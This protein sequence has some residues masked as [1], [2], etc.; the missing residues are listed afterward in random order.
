MEWTRL[1]RQELS[2]VTG[3]AAHDAEIIEELAEDLAQR[4]EEHRTHEATE[5]EALTYI[6]AE[7]GDPERLKARI[8][9]SRPARSRPP[10]P[11]R[12]GTGARMTSDLW[13][14]VRYAA[15]ILRRSPGFSLP[16]VLT[17]AVGIGAVTAIFS[18]IDGVLLK[19]VPY[20]EATRLIAV[21][22]T[23]RDSATE[24]EPASVPD[25]LDFGHRS[26]LVEAFGAIAAS[27]FNLTPSQGDPVRLAGLDV[28]PGLFALLGVRP[29]VGRLFSEA[30]YH[31]RASDVVL[32]SERLWDRM[33]QRDASI[34]GRTIRLDDRPRI[35]VGILPDTA[36]LGV[37]QW[38]LAADY[39]RGFA[40]R[41]ARS[42]VDAWVPL[43]LDPVALPRNTHPIL[44]VGRVA[45]GVSLDAA[46]GEMAAIMAALEREFPDDNKARGAHV[47]SLL[48]VV[49]GPVRPALGVLAAAVVL[50]LLL[51]SANVANLVLVRGTT[52][53]REVALRTAL[54]AT[55]ARLTRQFVIEN[56]LIATVAAVVGL[57]IA[58]GALR[59]L[60]ATAP[61]DVPRITTVALDANLFAAAL[62]LA[63]ILAVV[64]GA[65]PALQARRLDLSSVLISDETRTATGSRRSGA[66]RAWL[67][68]GEIALAVVLTVGA[69]LLIRSLWTLQAV[70]PGF[71]ADGVLKAEFQLPPSRYPQDFKQWP[72]FVEIHRFNTSLLR[73]VAGLPGIEAAALA[74]QHPLDAGFTN[75]F[76]VVG[77]EAEGRDW[78][79]I[80]LRRVTP[81]YFR[82][83]QVPLVEGRLFTDGDVAASKSV[84][85]I[86]EAAAAR[87]FP[88]RNPVGQQIRFW[89]TTRLVVGLVG[90]ERFHGLAEAPPPATYAPLAQAPSSAEVLLV[91]APDALAMSAV[92]RAAITREDPGLAIFGIEPL[93]ATLEESMSRRRFVMLLLAILAGMAMALAAVGIHAVLSYDV[94]RRTRE[95]GIR[96]ALG[97]RPGD[98]MR[99][100][101]G[102]GARLT[103]IGLGI[104]TAA[105]LLLTRFLSSLLFEVKPTDAATLVA[106]AGALAA[107][108]LVASYLPARRAIGTD[109][110]AAIRDE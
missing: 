3:D 108:A 58:G 87:F 62:A 107:I 103:A 106:S 101:V 90:N 80:A 63:A 64:F 89:G 39:S 79:E 68:V 29:S 105:S 102:R 110:L 10:A 104:G 91:R 46:Q 53:V 59:L 14:D 19:P 42:R 34:V 6:R 25:F 75:S 96:M 51:A 18:V 15:R 61:A 30:E 95:I 33:F 24:R 44:V 38:L 69:G 40:D 50:V 5:D 21:W 77:R 16:A 43:S 92:M 36:D 72:N 12:V 23:D 93:R 11:P 98:V 84:V 37:L 8:R 2:A 7:I 52:R 71:R 28:S 81:G 22:E 78:P 45:P 20:P 82:T 48:A 57:A 56:A 60:V 74:A 55:P 73:S 67:I 109:P 88:R 83:M 27:E 41:D 85:L 70:D 100:I 13:Q 94:A 97:A 86:N 66:A 49:F 9:L 4:F 17:L 26:R 65:M 32:I 99:G 1:V 47:E 54:G 76:T 31:A 35:V